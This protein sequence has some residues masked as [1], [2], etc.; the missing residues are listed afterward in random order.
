MPIAHHLDCVSRNF[1][2]STSYAVKVICPSHIR[3]CASAIGTRLRS[4]SAVVRR[5]VLH[6]EIDVVEIVLAL[7]I[8]LRTLAIIPRAI[9][10]LVMMSVEP[11]AAAMDMLLALCHAFTLVI[12]CG[13]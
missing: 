13:C 5:P 2:L 8:A 11:T 1:R 3:I 10:A 7:I 9:G 4:A 6:F 12:G